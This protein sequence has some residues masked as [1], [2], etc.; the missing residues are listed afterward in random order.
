[1][2]Q[3]W[4]FIITGLVS[5]ALYSM[6][7]TGV[8]LAYATTGLF[9]FAQGGI[10]FVC[11]Y[12]FF[13]LHSGAHLSTILSGALVILILGPLMGL[14]LDAIAFRRLAG[15]PEQA[16]IV[17]TVGLSIALPAFVL[18]LF[19]ELV[20]IG[21]LHLVVGAN[22]VPVS[23]GPS[24]A[25]LWH[26]FGS[27]SI[28]SDQVIIFA[29]AA[30]IALVVWFVVRHTRIGL[31]MRAA[32]DARRLAEIR[33]VDIPRAS[34]AAWGLSGLCCGIIGVAGGVVLGLNND[35][36][37]LLLFAAAAAMVVGRLESIPL[38]FVGGLALGVI[39]D[40]VAGYVN[41]G[42][43]SQIPGLRSSVPFIILLVGLMFLG[44]RRGRKA[45][46]AAEA[47]DA[48]A[49]LT[50][51]DRTWRQR[52]PVFIAIGLVVVYTMF[53]ADSFWAGLMAQGFVMGVIFLSFVVVTGLGGMVSL[54]QA[55]FVTAAS[56]FA[57]WLT[58]SIGLPFWVAAL[59]GTVIAVLVGVIV[60]LPALRLD[61]LALA[62]ATLALALTLD[63]VVFAIPSLGNT[64]Q[65]WTF[66]KLQIG[67]WNLAGSRAFAF[68]CL[69]LLGVLTVLIRNFERSPSGRAMLAVRGSAPA[70]QSSGVNHVRIKLI[71]FGFSA[72]IAGI[73]GIL[74]AMLLQNVTP[75]A[76]PPLAG[77]LWVTIAITF[78]IRRPAGA[79]VAG[80][81]AGVSPQL[82][83]YIT[84]STYLPL[85]LFG[86]GAV[87]LAQNPEGVLSLQ[88]KQIKWVGHNLS[89]G[90]QFT[91]SRLRGVGG[92][93]SGVAA[94][95][96][97]VAAVAG[98]A[99]ALPAETAATAVRPTESA[100]ATMPLHHDETDIALRLRSLHAGYGEIEVLHGVDLALKQGTI[101]A[102][103]GAN[104]AG[105]STLCAVLAGV[106]P[107]TSG[108][109][110]LHGRDIKKMHPGDR[111]EAG[112]FI[113]PE[114]R[115]IF[116]GMTVEDN[117]RI[118]LTT[119]HDLEAAFTRFPVLASRRKLDAGSLSGGEQ[120][121]LTL[122]PAFVRLPQ[123]LIADEPTL[124]LAPLLRTEIMGLF[125]ELCQEGVTV[126]LIE[127]KARDVLTIADQVAVLELGRIVWDRPRQE[128]DED[129]LTRVYLGGTTTYAATSP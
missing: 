36:Y 32:V 49:E 94:D 5:G 100:P 35:A 127:E 47:R 99:A 70:A 85:I 64:G 50:E 89:Q 103:L 6:M 13:E 16:R 52:V 1:M 66:P 31:E 71:T 8:V 25:K 65:G 74:L 26:L 121:L 82:F 108:D 129:E 53:I 48:P 93:A 128:V 123:V 81:A 4:G 54:A 77:L 110:L 109:L 69:I 43:L 115:G 39:Q 28:S 10:A 124:G 42:F 29:F 37:T 44:K 75:S 120:Q 79:I 122:A 38:A 41:F 72:A 40:L 78:G 83:S 2:S 18:L 23:L 46:T 105:K 15:A 20:N 106:V 102:L 104:G 27:A 97:E 80:L 24:P 17:G 22:S 55:G 111:V 45:G 73:G 126:L 51:S 92:A 68:F 9:N 33:G 95:D 21:H 116:P 84:T 30:V 3:F 118:W 67:P 7:A 86:L 119:S 34:R 56:L 11:A 58:V 14:G 63:Q 96:K 90:L 107:Q 62:L 125:S 19:T 114:S 60:A 88:V 61:G 59:C 87:G 76:N 101:T 112:L 57:G 117:L 98:A 91:Y 113:A 12:V